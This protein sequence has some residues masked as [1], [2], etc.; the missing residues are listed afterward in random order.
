MVLGDSAHDLKVQMSCSIGE[1]GA[2]EPIFVQNNKSETLSK[3]NP[4]APEFSFKF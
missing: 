3:I 1:R 4:L 2:T